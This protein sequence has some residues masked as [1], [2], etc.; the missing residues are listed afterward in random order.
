MSGLN[1]IVAIY[2]TY[3]ISSNMYKHDFKQHSLNSI[4]LYVDIHCNFNISEVIK[5]ADQ[6]LWLCWCVLF[7]QKCLLLYGYYISKQNTL[8]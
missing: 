1:K 7:A 2:I 8:D 4:K 6:F 3:K 5:S